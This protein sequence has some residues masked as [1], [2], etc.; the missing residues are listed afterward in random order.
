MAGGRLGQERANHLL[1]L[2]AKQFG[3]KLAVDMRGGKAS[4]IETQ[5]ILFDLVRGKRQSRIEMSAKSLDIIQR[6][7]PDTEKA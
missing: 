6:H 2:V 7:F 1:G 3:Q 4:F 5:A